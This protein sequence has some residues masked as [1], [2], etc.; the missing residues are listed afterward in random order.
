MSIQRSGRGVEAADTDPQAP[1]FHLGRSHVPDES[2]PGASLLEAAR[3]RSRQ[4]APS[5]GAGGRFAP[6]HKRTNHAGLYQLIGTQVHA[7]LAKT[8][9]DGR[10]DIDEIRTLVKSMLASTDINATMRRAISVAVVT[11]VK[12]YG[13][14]FW[15][16]ELEFVESEVALTA[17]SRCD[18]M[19]KL[20]D[21]RILID[22][23]KSG[24]PPGFNWAPTEQVKRYLE[25]ANSK[26]AH[27]FY[28][29]RV[30]FL[31]TPGLSA[32]LDA[33][34]RRIASGPWHEPLEVSSSRYAG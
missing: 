28:G 10:F 25:A 26:Y 13:R 31:R 29:L 8:V 27:S 6:G 3:E 19:W 4:L 33:S 9:L 1:V 7:A 15:S 34:G 12:T 14:F 5:A 30:C 32:T 11:Q 23:V 21:G 18:L 17:T 16:P 24:T 2:G 22:E 20:P